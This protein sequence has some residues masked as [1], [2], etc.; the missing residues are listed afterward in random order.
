MNRD[1]FEELWKKTEDVFE[2]LQTIES[3]TLRFSLQRRS[4]YHY[5]P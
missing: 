2:G 1:L 3:K 4:A 5:S